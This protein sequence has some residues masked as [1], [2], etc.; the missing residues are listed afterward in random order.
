[1]HSPILTRRAL[2]AGAGTAVASAALAVPYVNAASADELCS[3]PVQTETIT[4]KIERLS[5][6]LSAAMA[7][8]DGGDWRI[9]VAADDNITLQPTI[10]G[11]ARYRADLYL[12]QYRKAAMEADPTI[13]GW[14]ASYSVDTGGIRSIHAIR[15]A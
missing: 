13:T 6:A 4:D 11:S 14:D 1:M 8:Y 10:K 5:R 9:V 7:E 12:Q 15:S 3:A 2:I